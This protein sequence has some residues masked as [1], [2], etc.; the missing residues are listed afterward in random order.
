MVG[1]Q[2]WD[3]VAEWLDEKFKKNTRYDIKIQNIGSISSIGSIE[4]I[5]CI[6]I[7]ESIESNES[8]IESIGIIGSIIILYLELYKFI[9]L[10]FNSKL[11]LTM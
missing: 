10:Q 1:A 6:E 4:N 3:L 9:S 11:T 8:I 2:L 5:E 7:I